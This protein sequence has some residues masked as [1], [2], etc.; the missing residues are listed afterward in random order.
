MLTKR[1]TA[2]VLAALLYWREEMSPYGPPIMRP[3]FQ[4]VGFPRTKPL[5][6]REIDA[7]AVRWKAQQKQ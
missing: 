5:S 3:Y 6:G 7:L 2:T 1:E 4:S